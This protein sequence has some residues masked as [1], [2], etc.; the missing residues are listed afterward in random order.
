MSSFKFGNAR[1]YLSMGVN[2]TKERI[3]EMHELSATV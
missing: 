3:Y 1:E 2:R